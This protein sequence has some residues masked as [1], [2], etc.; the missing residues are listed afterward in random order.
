MRVSGG[1]AGHDHGEAAAHDHGSHDHGAADGHHD[2][3]A[4]APEDGL[5]RIFFTVIAN[6]LTGVAFGC[7]WWPAFALYRRDMDWR[8]GVLWGLGGFAAFALAPAVVLP[9]E[10]PGAAAAAVPLRQGLWAPD[11]CGHGRRIWP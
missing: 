5:E 10:V 6:C 7:C 8:K 11:R 1:E 9:P 2:G 3:T 4:W